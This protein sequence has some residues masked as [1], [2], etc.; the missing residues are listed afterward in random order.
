MTSGIG[1]IAEI[2]YGGRHAGR[3][4]GLRAALGKVGAWSPAG[5]AIGQFAAGMHG[6]KDFNDEPGQNIV[7]VRNGKVVKTTPSGQRTPSVAQPIF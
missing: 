5:I 1:P 7:G 4:V 2:G 3:V 6:A